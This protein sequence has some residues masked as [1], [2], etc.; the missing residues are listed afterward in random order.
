MIGN[1]VNA[2]IWTATEPSMGVV[3]A[4]LPS[5]RPLFKKIFSGDYHGPTF[6]NRNT[7]SAQAY[8]SGTSSRH[9][10]SR[11]KGDQGDLRS[12]TPLEEPV[13]KPSAPWGH[14]VLVHG[15]R[16]Q[17]PGGEDQISLEEMQTPSKSIKVKTEVTLISSQRL[18]YRDQLF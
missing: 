13:K 1:Y 3:S 6:R 4:C 8:G 9:I 2:G 16:I 14:N 7:N 5:M 18:E 17:R 11:N 15:G 12:F 10:M